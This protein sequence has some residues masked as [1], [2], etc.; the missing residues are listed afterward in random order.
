MCG[1]V[2]SDPPR[3]SL[4]VLAQVV[5]PSPHGVCVDPVSELQPEAPS[6]ALTVG[7]RFLGHVRGVELLLR[8]TELLSRPGQVDTQENQHLDLTWAF[9]ARDGGAG[10]LWAPT[11]TSAQRR[12]G[13]RSQSCSFHQ[14]GLSPRP[15]LVRARTSPLLASLLA[16][17]LPSPGSAAA[18]LGHREAG[19][20]SGR[21][22]RLGWKRASAERE[23]N[24]RAQGEARGLDSVME[25]K[26][27]CFL[28]ESLQKSLL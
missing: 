5:N 21:Q 11:P 14:E 1:S 13:L 15:S 25:M 24:D 3:N 19:G 23:R 20:P 8:E 16:V 4:L 7:V 28:P 10:P 17:E 12:P 6:A 22:R 2:S 9:P 27:N 26:Q 18:G